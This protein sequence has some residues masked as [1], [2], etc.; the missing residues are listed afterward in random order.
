MSAAVHDLPALRLIPYRYT[1]YTGPSPDGLQSSKSLSTR[2]ACDF[3]MESIAH[4]GLAAFNP[5]PS[6]YQVFRNV[7]DFG[8]VG[9]G[10][11]DDT[12]AI[13]AAIDSGSR[14]APGSC[15]SSTVTPAVVYFPAGTYLISSSIIHYYYTQLIGN[16]NCLPV[17]RASPGFSSGSNIGLIDADPY[18]SSGNLSYGATNVFYRQVRNLVLDLTQLPVD[19][20]VAG[21]H[22]PTAQATSVQNVQFMMSSAPGTQHIGMFIESGS[23]GFMNDLT[24]T[25]GSVGLNVGN[26]QFTMRNLTFENV[27]TAINQLWDW[28]WTYK[29]ITIDNCQVGIAMGSTDP[30]SGGQTVGSV[31][32]LD[33]S[34]TNTP[35][36][37]QTSRNSTSLPPSGNSLI[38]ENVILSNVSA[39]VQGTSGTLLAGSTGSTTI[40]AWGQGTS[41]TPTGPST[42][43]GPISA[44]LRPASLLIGTDYY[45]RS[46]PQYETQPVTGFVSARA[47]GAKGDGTTD[48][49]AALQNAINTAN[50]EGDVLFVDH[51][52]YLVTNT[53]Y[54]PAG[55]RIVG[56]SYSVILSSGAF[57]DDMTTP[58]PVVRLGNAGEAG[59]VE[60]S[61]MIVST[62]GQQQGAVLIEYNLV[63]SSTSPSGIWD[64][65][66]RVGGF[67]GSDL[68]V[69]QCPTTA[70]QP[71]QDCL[72][73]YLDLHV[74]SGSS[75][76]YLENNWLWVADH[77]IEDTS[78]TQISIY[79]GRGMLIE[80]I[81]GNIWLVGTAVEHHTLYQYQFANTQNIFAGQVGRMQSVQSEPVADYPPRRRYRP[82]RPTISRT[83][84]PRGLGHSTVPS[85]TR[86]SPRSLSMTYPPP[87]HGASALS[88]LKRSSFTALAC[89]PS[90]TIT[91][92]LAR[93]RATARHAKAPSCPS[94]E[95]AATSTFTTST[96]S[97]Y[98]TC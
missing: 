28:G 33:S 5:N 73:A 21:I 30:T 37:V 63:S 94:R 58:Q 46:K 48:D 72:A 77:D 13:N 42:F 10:V 9:D 11:T 82:R 16:A 39:A 62:K 1:N 24:F 2:D 17:I 26:Q 89:T 91:T 98:I 65:H 86:S 83:H 31:I 51:G 61:D 35:I 79:G 45:Q 92:R 75:G 55:S 78:L 20:S 8:A 70:A 40:S 67:A 4:Q 85:T 32:L 34:I 76:L 41:Y 14:C 49:T 15:Q 81:A 88:T 66:T 36:G 29:G 25:G 90:S 23:G 54:I 80:S 19:S 56:E 38:L 44:N 27:G 59:S 3:W 53:I 50:S 96:P 7:K 60:M 95:A 22:W 93:T 47:L 84:R 69:A 52:D 12:A 74:T 6:A 57:F 87:T 71:N 43:Q 64:V 97:E 68:Q 18:E